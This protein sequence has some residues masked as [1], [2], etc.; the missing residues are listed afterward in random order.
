MQ[1]PFIGR[2]AIGRGAN[3]GCTAQAV[4]LVLQM[5]SLFGPLPATGYRSPLSAPSWTF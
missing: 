2:G 4:Q 3:L 5:I 1:Q